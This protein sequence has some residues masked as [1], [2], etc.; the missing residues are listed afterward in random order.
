MGAF[1]QSLAGVH[2]VYEVPDDDL[3][4]DVLI[5][6]MTNADEVRVGMGYFSSHS[7]AQLSAGLAAFLCNR[8]GPLRLLISPEISQEDR[9]AIAQGVG[10]PQAVVD[11]LAQRIFSSQAAAASALTT[12]AQQCLAFL[13]ASGRLELR[14]VL[15]K[16]G[17][18][19]KKQWLFC[20]ESAWAAVHGSGNATESGLVTNGEQMTV[21]RAWSDGDAARIRVERLLA[22]WDRQ[23]NNRSP[24]SLTLSASQGLRFVVKPA[25]PP[26]TSDDFW[27]AWQ[28]DFEA[29]LE[30]ELP[31]DV[32]APPGTKLLSIPEGTEWRTGPYQHQGLAVDAFLAK[33]GRGV[34]AI[35]TGGG[36]TQTALIAATALQSEQPAGFLVIIL[37]PSRP[38][39][40]QWAAAVRRFGIEPLL[41]SLAEPTSRRA[42]LQ[43]LQVALSLNSKRTSVVVTTNALFADDQS[44]RDLIERLPIPVKILLIGDEMHNLGA[45][46]IR[47]SLPERAFYRLGL[48]ATP[49][50]QYDPDGTDKLLE[51]FGQP[52][53]EFTLKEAI[54]SG[55][56]T[57]YNYHLH[58]VSLTAEEVDRWM[59]L[60]EQLRR[61]GFRVDDD[62]ATVGMSPKVERL[63]RER[64]AVLENATN[65]ISV[66]RSILLAMSRDR[67]RRCLIYCSAKPPV[68]D[69]TDRQIDR[70]NS[71]LSDLAVI[72]HQFTADETSGGTAD[73]LLEAFGRGDY[74]VLTAMKVLD[75]GVDIP[76]TDLAFVLAS[77]T[78]RREWVQRRGR[79]LRKAPGKLIATLHDFIVV[80][81]DMSSTPGRAIL[82]SELERAEEFAVLAENEW[83]PDGPRTTMGRLDT[84][85]WRRGVT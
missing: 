27:K 48:S 84:V 51:Y 15:M 41:P 36:K 44:I 72:S 68:V 16:R 7:L 63:L 61:A 26:P 28:R 42:L 59:E 71:L 13:V 57:P 58:E 76:Q 24:H 18:Y 9:D 45:P 55:C 39:M 50:R 25:T 35:A 2:P 49:V 5:P 53:L 70:V 20:G 14:F 80:P 83:A 1:K 29:G 46:V 54:N 69:D 64:R 47:G 81:P 78:V 82:R 37:V 43:E 32:R 65:K 33:Q 22:Q 74:Q 11:Q 8:A 21:D 77:S 3:V 10:E 60:T 19:H 17:M 66:L 30:P 31:P 34:M 73:S 79:I 4:R 75:E 85:A 52:V 38:L 56:L 40:M 67:L 6:A 62:G 23:W 12:H